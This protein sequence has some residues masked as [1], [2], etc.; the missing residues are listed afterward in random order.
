MEEP[1]EEGCLG[2]TGEWLRE[3]EKKWLG[4][5]RGQLQ[6]QRG[7]PKQGLSNISC[8]VPLSQGR[9]QLGA[10]GTQS[11]LRAHRGRQGP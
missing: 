2:Q 8:R 1:W 9:G 3:P 11:S 5:R 6:E 4:Q 7:S 10:Q